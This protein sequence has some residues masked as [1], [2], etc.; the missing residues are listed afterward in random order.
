MAFCRVRWVWTDFRNQESCRLPECRYVYRTSRTLTAV[1]IFTGF[2][3]SCAH[4]RGHGVRP[5]LIQHSRA[6]SFC[7]E[8]LR[9]LLPELL[10]Q[11]CEPGPHTCQCATKIASLRVGFA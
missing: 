2:F 3:G 8:V 4:L 11:D 9:T 5:E 10:I 7:G 6:L 1:I